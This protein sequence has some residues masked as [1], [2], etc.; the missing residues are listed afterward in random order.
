M[1]CSSWAADDFGAM[2]RGLYGSIAFASFE[3]MVED[4]ISRVDECCVNYML[5]RLASEVP[6]DP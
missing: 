2:L 1:L 6:S 4:D 3:G 5:R